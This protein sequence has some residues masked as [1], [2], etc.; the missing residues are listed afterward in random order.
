MFLIL[1]N[2]IK[3]MM[4]DIEIAREAKITPI[5]MIADKLKIDERYV[6]CYGKFKAKINLDCFNPE[7]LKGKLIL[8][9]AINPTKVG[10]GKTTVSIGLADGLS[11]I[12]ES[13]SLALR[14]PSMGPVFGLKG[15]ATGGGY[16]QIIPMDD[17]NLHFTR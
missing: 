16:S 12:G 8:V 4:T 17:I 10:E 7:K 13:V 2:L 1:R 15:G 5:Q 9:T 11:K 6:E 14:E 3:Y